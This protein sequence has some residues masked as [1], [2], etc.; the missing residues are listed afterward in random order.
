MSNATSSS[1]SP[2]P[3]GRAYLLLSATS[4]FWGANTVFG[5][6]AVGEVSPMALVSLRWFGALLLLVVFANRYIRNDWKVLRQHLLFV[7]FMGAL[8]FASFN[9]LFYIAAYSTTALNIGI[10]QGSIPVFVLTGAF[11][12]FRTTVTKL[13][14]GGVVLTVLGVALVASG[15]NLRH[16]SS[17][18]F[19]IGD[20]L[21]I[22]ACMLYSGYTLGLRNRPAVSSLGL[23]TVMAAAAFVTSLPMVGVE[24]QLGQFQW[25]TTTGWVVIAL[26]TVFPSFLAQIFFIQGVEL[27]GPSR[28]GIFVNLVPVFAS[29]LAVAYLDEAF[30]VYHAMALG[31]VLGGIWLSERG[32]AGG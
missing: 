4:F 30:E 2:K 19:N 20:L 8:G 29:I 27:I 13:Q 26:V 16:L 9:G 12:V 3:S 1:N 28:A 21:M 22:G 18:A 31:F 11:L 7:S 15:G 25:P 32:K 23:F 24:M 14:I 5:K 17:L 10:I 6:L